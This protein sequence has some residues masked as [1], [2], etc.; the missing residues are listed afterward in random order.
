[1]GQEPVK[2]GPIGRPATS[3]RNYH[4]SLRKTPEERSS[5]LLHGGRMKSSKEYSLVRNFQDTARLSFPLQSALWT[6]RG[7]SKEASN[8]A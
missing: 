8:L 7:N 2:M 3:V 6:Q 5:H 1:M 4:H